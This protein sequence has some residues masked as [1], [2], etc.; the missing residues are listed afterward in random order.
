MRNKKQ[1]RLVLSVE[2]LQKSVAVEVDAWVVE[3]APRPERR[4]S[5]RL[6]HIQPLPLRLRGRGVLSSD[7]LTQKASRTKSPT[8]K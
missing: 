4:G 8:G 7:V 6:L 3:R 1:F 2:L 5:G